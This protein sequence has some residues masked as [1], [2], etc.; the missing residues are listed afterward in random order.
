MAHHIFSRIFNEIFISG[1]F[2]LKI[3]FHRNRR[4]GIQDE[5]GSFFK[6][7]MKNSTRIGCILV[8]EATRYLD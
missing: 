3:L 4:F 5:Q 7:L 2:F 1:L 6:I 8:I